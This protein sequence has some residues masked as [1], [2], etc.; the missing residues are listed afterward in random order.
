MRTGEAKTGAQTLNIATSVTTGMTRYR[1]SSSY[2]GHGSF[3]S[4]RALAVRPVTQSDRATTAL[5]KTQ[6]SILRTIVF[7]HSEL[8]RATQPENRRPQRAC[9]PANNPCTP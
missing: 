2:Q 4:T 5:W 8:Y 9:R 1:Q 7:H 6:T 3:L